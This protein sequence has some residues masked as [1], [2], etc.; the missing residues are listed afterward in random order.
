MAGAGSP[1][2]SRRLVAA[3]TDL[4]RVALP[5]ASRCWTSSWGCFALRR[6]RPWTT[7]R[8][9]AERSIRTAK[10]WELP[11]VRLMQE[12]V[13]GA[14][15]RTPRY[16]DYEPVGERTTP[17]VPGSR[18]GEQC[19]GDRPGIVGAFVFWETCK[20]GQAAPPPLGLSPDQ[21]WRTACCVGSLGNQQPRLP[22]GPRGTSIRSGGTARPRRFG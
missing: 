13:Q 20:T 4:R 19:R 11:R 22:G 17:G 3:L 2:V 14:V 15:S 7:S 8:T 1:Q 5:N 9:P 16:D 6:L 18:Y 12:P 21:R 10:D